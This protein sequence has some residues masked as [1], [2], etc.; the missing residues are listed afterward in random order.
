MSLEILT[1]RSVIEL[2]Y[3]PHISLLWCL[4]KTHWTD[5]L[6]NNDHL[7]E[8]LGIFPRPTEFFRNFENNFFGEISSDNIVNFVNTIC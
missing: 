1:F 5:S 6:C 2:I 4:F 7:E 3:F 8:A